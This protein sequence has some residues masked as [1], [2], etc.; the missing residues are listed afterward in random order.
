[1]NGSE[2]DTEGDA[3]FRHCKAVYEAMLAESRTVQAE[4]DDDV[5]MV[6]YEGNLTTLITDK[7]EG[8]G[9]ATPYYTKTTQ[10]LK[11]L[12]CIRQLRRGGGTSPSLWELVTEPDLNEYEKYVK[13][14]V[15][16]SASAM[17]A[18]QIRGLNER[19]SVLEAALQ[20]PTGARVV[21]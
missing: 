2:N 17:M 12:N 15:P 14:G 4:E 10:A 9:L 1:M 20:I 21:S 6:V 3:V 5:T 13:T 18:Q 16:R 11:G 19:V 7:H 8:L